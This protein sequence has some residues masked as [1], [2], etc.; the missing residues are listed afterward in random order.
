[1]FPL[2]FGKKGASLF[3]YLVVTA[4]ILQSKTQMPYNKMLLLMENA[5]QRTKK[6]NWMQIESF[7]LLMQCIFTCEGDS[8]I[9]YEVKLK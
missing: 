9:S 8:F 1:M 6:I 3:L 5:K 4:V 7:I 2:F